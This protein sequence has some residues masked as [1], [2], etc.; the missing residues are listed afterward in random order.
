M[1]C[2]RNIFNK[3]IFNKF[4]YTAIK[5]TKEIVKYEKATNIFEVKEVL[6]SVCEFLEFKDLFQLHS[7]NKTMHGHSLLFKR[8]KN[9]LKDIY[10]PQGFTISGSYLLGILSKFDN[11]EIP[12]DI[13]LYTNLEHGPEVNALFEKNGYTNKEYKRLYFGNCV[14]IEG[15]QKFEKNETLKTDIIFVDKEVSVHDMIEENFDVSCVKNWYDGKTLYIKDLQ[16][17]VGLH[18][19]GKV[20][21][22]ENYKNS[23]YT[24][25][26]KYLSRGYVIDTRGQNIATTIYSLR[27][28]LGCTYGF[29]SL[30][31]YMPVWI[32]FISHMPIMIRMH[33]NHLI[34]ST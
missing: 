30:E 1:D 19:E 16:R 10:I 13:D 33:G 22:L 7:T 11:K 15:V 8:V 27:H 28:N 23:Y 14:H 17:T 29:I 32:V 18:P 6:F 31:M 26:H 25:F 4:N 34:L 21:I 2:L 20:A 24:R 9:S 12:N 5:E 3:F